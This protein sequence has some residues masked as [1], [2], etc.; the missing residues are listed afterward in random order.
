MDYYGQ[1]LLYYFFWHGCVMDI[2]ARLKEARQA[3]FRSASAAAEALGVSGATYGH[4]EN[5]TRG[6]PTDTVER[7]ARFFG[8]SPAWL[9]FGKDDGV[10]AST[11]S[12]ATLVTAPLVGWVQAGVW[13]EPF[14]DEVDHGDPVP[15]QPHPKYPNATYMVLDVRGDS[16]DLVAPEGSR[17]V[18]IPWAETGLLSPLNGQTIVAEQW[19]SDPENDGAE[20]SGNVQRTLKKVRIEPG[21]VCLDPHSSNPRHKPLELDRMTRA[22]ALVVGVFRP[23]E[24]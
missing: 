13:Q 5:G 6:I 15:I 21:R 2:H 14:D 12:A 17:V 11:G 8:V 4:H 19:D 23:V 16:Y 18:V 9:M 22:F 7:Y 1:S 3:R 10:A 20:H 24:V